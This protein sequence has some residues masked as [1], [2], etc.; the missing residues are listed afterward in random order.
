[1]AARFKEFNDEWK[2][3]SY[4]EI[5]KINQGLQIEIRNRFT[6]NEVNRYFYITNQFLKNNSKEIYFIE[7]PSASVICDVDYKLPICLN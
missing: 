4:K 1:M 5:T 2:L 3:Y 6:E 7:N